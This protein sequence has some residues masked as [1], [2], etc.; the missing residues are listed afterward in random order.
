MKDFCLF[1]LDILR[2]E[3][4]RIQNMMETLA[5]VTER[6]AADYFCILIENSDKPGGLVMTPTFEASPLT[7][8]LFLNFC[9]TILSQIL[10]RL[11]LSAVKSKQNAPSAQN[12]NISITF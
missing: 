8:V 7:T 3:S 6:I 5:H 11:D 9:F 4:A 1:Y 10:K 2:L 12:I